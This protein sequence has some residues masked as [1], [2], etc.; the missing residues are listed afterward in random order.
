MRRLQHLLAMCIAF[1]SVISAPRIAFYEELSWLKISQDFR[2][3]TA[4]LPDFF[5]V[6]LLIITLARLIISQPYRTSLLASYQQW[7]GRPS[8]WLWLALLG[9]IAISQLWAFNPLFSQAQLLHILACLCMA[10]VVMEL[11]KSGTEAP[12]LM[13]FVASGIIQS[14]IA[15]L[16]IINQSPLGLDMVGEVSRPW[17]EPTGF[18]RAS[19][20]AMHSNY[21]AGYLMIGLACAL[22]LI[23]RYRT[24]KIRWVWGMSSLIITIGLLCTLSRSGYVGTL[25][26]LLPLLV[27]WLIYLPIKK[28]LIV[29]TILG[30]GAVLA[31]MFGFFV[32]LNGS[33]ENVQTRFLSGR[34]FYF[35]D[36]WLVITQ[37]P[38]TGVG[39]GNIMLGV[40]QNII[41]TDY[42]VLPVHN[43]YLFIWAELGII[44]MGLFIMACLIH[45][46]DLRHA[47]SGIRVL[48]GALWMG[49]CVI[50]LFD[51][52]FW[53]VQPFRV[54]FFL[55]IALGWVIIHKKG[56]GSGVSV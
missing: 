32:L 2:M 14:L 5:M 4:S 39:A 47:P 55:V 30:M 8:G 38:I 19:G 10:W 45:L 46:W 54:V 53:G 11:V 29:I 35:D 24:Q 48:F 43:V 7:I 22:W 15:L 42:D 27:S 25:I 44:G 1:I 3:I 33:V 40:A 50:M 23:W 56:V 37:H 31:G 9:W 49:I 36:S 34:Q 16:Q 20:L 41:N 26:L 52:Y 21:L 6:C 28:R 18:Y 12:L 17:Y 51:N 13:A